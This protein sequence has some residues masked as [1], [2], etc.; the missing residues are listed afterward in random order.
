MQ[1]EKTKTS[2]ATKAISFAWREIS[3][4]RSSLIRTLPFDFS[5]IR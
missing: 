3:K 4:S 5:L 2:T 1:M